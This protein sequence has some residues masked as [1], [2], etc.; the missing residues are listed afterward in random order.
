MILLF[1]RNII[2]LLTIQ[3]LRIM[4]KISL[5]LLFVCGILVSFT[6]GMQY[7]RGDVNY[8]GKV[9]IGDVSCLI[10][11]LL[12]GEWPDEPVAPEEP[13]NETFTVQGVTFTMVGVKCGTFLMG[14]TEE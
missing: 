4:R 13:I 10:D 1:L 11:Y 12:N 7:P 9:S 5:A 14:G 6:A 8:D 3:S 2:R